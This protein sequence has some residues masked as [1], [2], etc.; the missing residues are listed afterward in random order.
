MAVKLTTTQ[1]SLLMMESLS[2]GGFVRDI[3]YYLIRKWQK[4]YVE[5]ASKDERIQNI[6]IMNFQDLKLSNEF[7]FFTIFN[8]LLNPLSN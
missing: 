3:C 2:L 1:N 5:I 8:N 4:I 7:S 6:K